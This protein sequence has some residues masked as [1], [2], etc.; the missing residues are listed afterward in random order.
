MKTKKV[1]IT[2]IAEAMG[3]SPVSI[4]R[5]LG[6]QPGISSELKEAVVKKAAEM[7]YI[8]PK[9]H[10]PA[11]IL[12]LHQKPYSHDNSNFS[13]MVQGIEL[14]LQKAESDY[15]I[16]FVDKENQNKLILPYRLSRGFKFDGVILIGRFNLEYAAFI[17]QQIPN[18]I[19]YTGYSPAYDYDSVW[20]SFLNAGY[21]QCKYLLDRGHRRIAFL[22]DPS[23]YRNKEKKTGITS[24]LEDYGVPVDD[25]LF[26]SRGGEL[27]AK[28]S[29]LQAEGRL[30]S[31]FI[32]DHDFTAVELLRILQEQG[33]KVPGDVSVL[34]SGNT[35]VSAFSLPALTTMDLNIDYSCRTV[36]ATLLKRMAEPGK[37]AENIAILSTLVER[38]SVREL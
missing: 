6:N 3:L 5:A 30:P 23:A 24:A 9:K 21:K 10:T 27:P 32:C 19:F 34:S 16:E 22:S 25:E 2:H 33:I 20:F 35:E 28:L 18:L 11:R 36:V 17:H 14:A 38:D 7:G 29:A 15:S 13:F 31:A 8:K 12:V 1:T 37:P 26:L 4:S